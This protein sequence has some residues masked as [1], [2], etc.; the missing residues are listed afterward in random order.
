MVIEG[1]RSKLCCRVPAFEHSHYIPIITARFTD[2]LVEIGD[3][4]VSKPL[5]IEVQREYTRV[6]P[7]DYSRPNQDEQ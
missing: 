1:Y 4:G 6:H 3:T 5:T 7:E 2:T